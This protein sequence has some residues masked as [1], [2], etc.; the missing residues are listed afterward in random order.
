VLVEHATARG[1]VGVDGESYHLVVMRKFVKNPKLVLLPVP[2]TVFCLKQVKSNICSFQNN[3]EPV[4]GTN[5]MNNLRLNIHRRISKHASFFF[6]W[7]NS[8]IGGS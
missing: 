3:I 2:S 5:F 7:P 8:S 1:V 6:F 4:L